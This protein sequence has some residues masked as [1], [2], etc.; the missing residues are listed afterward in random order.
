MIECYDG[1]GKLFGILPALRLRTPHHIACVTRNSSAC[2]LNLI[3][4]RQ[5]ASAAC[6][7]LLIN[8]RLSKPWSTILKPASCRLWITSLKVHTHSGSHILCRIFALTTDIFMLHS[9]RSLDADHT[10]KAS[11]QTPSAESGIYS[12][13]FCSTY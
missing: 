13:C 5:W 7:C 9:C 4:L 8:T 10:R 11:R 3:V 1:L 6:C 12:S 2:L